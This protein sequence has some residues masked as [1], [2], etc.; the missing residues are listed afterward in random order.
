MKTVDVALNSE[1]LVAITTVDELF[2]V[3]Q[4]TPAQVNDF[5]FNDSPLKDYS[6]GEHE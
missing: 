6:G 4:Q 3:Y 5:T 1:G 2:C